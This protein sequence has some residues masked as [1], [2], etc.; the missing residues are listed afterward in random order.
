MYQ[1]SMNNDIDILVNWALNI[2]CLRCA[3]ASAK[4]SATRG[5]QTGIMRSILRIEH[6]ITAD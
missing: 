6:F 4:A 2:S 5:R 3:C 1:F